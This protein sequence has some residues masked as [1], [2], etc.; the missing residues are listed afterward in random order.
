MK[1]CFFG[2]FL[3]CRIAYILLLAATLTARVF[4][5]DHDVHPLLNL[6]KLSK[7]PFPS[8]RFTVRDSGQ[9]TNL[10]VHLPLPDCTARPSDCI[11][12]KLLNQLD[13][14]NL[15]P[16]LSIPFDGPI[17]VSTV[18]SKTVFLVSLGDSLNPSQHRGE[19][20]G[21][22]QIVWDVATTTLHTE[23]DELLAQ[24]TRYA[25][26]VTNGIHDTHGNP[27]EATEDFR[28]FRET[29]YGGYNH[30]LLAAI[31]AARPLA[32]RDPHV[33]TSSA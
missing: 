4:A 14:F 26:I 8:N 31:H 28:D 23:T 3:S 24:H 22:N 33:V 7:S 30:D 9:N 17:D 5:G 18:S 13:G 1:R 20:V 25:L 21:I 27:V 32:W 29:V 19:V 15:Q 11:D 2:K 12:T 6:E 16:R 10:R